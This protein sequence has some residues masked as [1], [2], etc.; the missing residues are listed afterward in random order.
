M[1]RYGRQVRESSAEIG[2]LADRWY[3]KSLSLL[4]LVAVGCRAPRVQASQDTNAIIV[5]AARE[6]NRVLIC[7]YPCDSIALDTLVRVRRSLPIGRPSSD[8]VVL[9]LSSSVLE[10]VWGKSV[11]LIP[12]PLQRGQEEEEVSIVSFYIIQADSIPPGRTLVGAVVAPAG[13]LFKTFAIP[14]ILESGEWRN[15][16]SYLYYE[17]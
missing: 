5:A 11:K 15:L 13:G 12:I 7:D 17:P 10:G 16:G 14:L 1:T 3:V 6:L 9:T 8:P 4:T 2:R